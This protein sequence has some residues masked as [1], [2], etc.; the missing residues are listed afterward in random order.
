MRAMIVVIVKAD[1]S[2]GKSNPDDEKER[3]QVRVE[4]KSGFL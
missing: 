3:D 1:G 2:V 4:G